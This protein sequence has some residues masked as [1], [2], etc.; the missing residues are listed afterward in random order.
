MKT[1]YDWVLGVC[2]W[3]P[4]F[5]QWWESGSLDQQHGGKTGDNSN[6]ITMHDSGPVGLRFEFYYLYLWI[7]Y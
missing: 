3:Q 6:T 2:G 7:V 4:S 1:W 5:V